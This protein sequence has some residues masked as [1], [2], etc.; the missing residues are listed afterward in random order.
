MPWSCMVI[1]IWIRDSKKKKKKK[2]FRPTYPNFF[3]HVTGNTHT[4]L[5]GL[6]IF[7]T[8]RTFSVI[9]SSHIGNLWQVQLNLHRSWPTDWCNR[10]RLLLSYGQDESFWKEVKLQDYLVK[11]YGTVWK[12]LSQE[13][14]RWNIHALSILVQKLW[15]TLK[16]CTRGPLCRVL[17][18]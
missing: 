7:V 1:M 10:H 4:F 3:G 15:E 5:F 2:I 11:S 16:F 9:L 6:I 8:H 17:W 13:M 14:H 18:Q 12:A